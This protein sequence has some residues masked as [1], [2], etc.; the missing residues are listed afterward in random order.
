MSDSYQVPQNTSVN[1]IE[2][3]PDEYVIPF[4]PELVGFILADKKLTTYRFGGNYD[5]LKVGDTVGIQNSETK[6]IVGKARITSKH[7]TTFKDLPIKAGTHESYKDKEH[8]RA[9]LS[10]YYAYIGRPI[11]DSDPFLV[12]DFSLLNGQAR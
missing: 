1:N 10:G 6:E 4:A 8:Q 11:T 12:L 7:Q 3:K 2:F 9:V 5:Y